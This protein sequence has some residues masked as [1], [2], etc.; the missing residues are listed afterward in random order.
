MTKFWKWIS[1]WSP[2]TNHFSYFQIFMTTKYVIAWHEKITTILVIS[3]L[4]VNIR[5]DKS[6]IKKFAYS[7]QYCFFNH[8]STNQI[9][10]SVILALI[11]KTMHFIR[12]RMLDWQRQTE[13]NVWY[14]LVYCLLRL[15]YQLLLLKRRR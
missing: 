14:S 2:L 1:E 7:N 12:F 3:V 10:G 6:K 13:I 9:S 5:N 4:Y 15:L 11:G 8:M